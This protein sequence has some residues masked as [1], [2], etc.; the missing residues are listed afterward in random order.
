[1]EFRRPPRETFGGLVPGGSA[2]M[3][4]RLGPDMAIGMGLRVKQPGERMVATI[5]N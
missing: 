1:M 3:R 5:W 2:H 4:F